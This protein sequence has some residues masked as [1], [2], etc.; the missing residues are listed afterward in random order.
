MDAGPHGIIGRRRTMSGMKGFAQNGHGNAGVAKVKDAYWRRRSKKKYHESFALDKGYCSLPSAQ[1]T[2]QKFRQTWRGSLESRRRFCS[3]RRRRNA[4]LNGRRRCYDGWCDGGHAVGRRRWA[5]HEVAVHAYRNEQCTFPTCECEWS[6]WTSW[7]TGCGVA[8]SKRSK[9]KKIAKVPRSAGNSHAFACPANLAPSP[10]NKNADILSASTTVVMTRNDFSTCGRCV[11]HDI[12]AAKT[13]LRDNADELVCYTNDCTGP[14][15]V[16]YTHVAASHQALCCED[17]PRCSTFSCGYKTHHKNG[18]DWNWNLRCLKDGCKDSGEQSHCCEQN[19]GRCNEVVCYNIWDGWLQK[20]SASSIVCVGQPCGKSASSLAER[21]NCCVEGCANPAAAD[22]RGFQAPQGWLIIREDAAVAYPPYPDPSRRRRSNWATVSTTRLQC[23]DSTHV[24]T[25]SFRSVRCIASKEPLQ[26]DGGSCRE[27]CVPKTGFDVSY[28]A[29][30]ICGKDFVKDI[31]DHEKTCA[32]HECGSFDWNTCCTQRCLNDPADHYGFDAKG[33]WARLRERPTSSAG[34]GSGAYPGENWKT[35]LAHLSCAGSTH[36]PKATPKYKCAQPGGTLQLDLQD[37]REKC[38]VHQNNLALCTS[39]NAHMTSAHFAVKT[40]ANDYCSD[41]RCD[42]ASDA[43]TCCRKKCTHPDVQCPSGFRKNTSNFCATAPNSCKTL[44]DNDNDPNFRSCCIRVCTSTFCRVSFAGSFLKSGPPECSDYNCGGKE[45]E[46]CCVQPCSKPNVG[47]NQ[48]GDGFELKSSGNNDWR[49]LL[50]NQQNCDKTSC[51]IAVPGQS[52]TSWTTGKLKC[53]STHAGTPRYRCPSAKSV[54]NPLSVLALDAGSCREKCRSDDKC[55]SHYQVRPASDNALCATNRCGTSDRPACCRMMCSEGNVVDF[56][57]SS[58]DYLERK[59]TLSGEVCAKY[60][61]DTQSDKE[62]CCRQQCRAFDSHLSGVNCGSGYSRIDNSQTVQCAA[63]ACTV[64]ADK[65]TCCRETCGRRGDTFCNAFKSGAAQYFKRIGNAIAATKCSSVACAGNADRNT[66]CEIGCTQAKTVVPH[67]YLI[68]DWSH[69]L[70]NAYPRDSS[71]DEVPLSG[72][73]CDTSKLMCDPVSHRVSPLDGDTNQCPTWQCAGSNKGLTFYGC[74]ELCHESDTMKCAHTHKRTPRPPAET[75]LCVSNRCKNTHEADHDDVDTCCYPKCSDRF[76]GAPNNRECPPPEKGFIA[77]G[78]RD[79]NDCEDLACDSVQETVSCCTRRRV[80]PHI[81]GVTPDELGIFVSGGSLSL[82]FGGD[83]TDSAVVADTSELDCKDERVWRD[84]TYQMSGIFSTEQRLRLC[85]TNDKCDL[86]DFNTHPDVVDCCL[87][88]VKEPGWFCDSFHT[89]RFY[90]TEEEAKGACDMGFWDEENGEVATTLCYGYQ[91]DENFFNFDVK[92]TY[93]GTKGLVTDTSKYGLYSLLL[94]PIEKAGDEETVTSAGTEYLN[95]RM[96]AGNED[97]AMRESYRRHSSIGMKPNCVRVQDGL[98]D[99]RYN[100]T[101]IDA[102]KAT[103]WLK[104]S[105]LPESKDLKPRLDDVNPDMLNEARLVALFPL[106]VAQKEIPGLSA[107]TIRVAMNTEDLEELEEEQKAAAA[108]HAAMSSFASSATSFRQTADEKNTGEQL[109][110]HDSA[111][112]GSQMP[113]V[114]DEKRHRARPRR[115]TSTSFSA[116]R[117]EEEEDEDTTFAEKLQKAVEI[118]LNVY[119]EVGNFTTPVDTSHEATDADLGEVNATEDDS[120]GARLLSLIRKEETTMKDAGGEVT[121]KAAAALHLQT[122]DAAEGAAALS[123]SRAQDGASLLQERQLHEEHG[124]DA[125]RTKKSS[126]QI[127]VLAGKIEPADEGPNPFNFSLYFV[128]T[129]P[130]EGSETLKKFHNST[131]LDEAVRKTLQKHILKEQKNLTNNTTTM[132][133]QGIQIQLVKE[134]TFRGIAGGEDGH[135]AAASASFSLADVGDEANLENLE[136]L[137]SVMDRELD[138]ELDQEMDA[139]VEASK[140]SS[141]LSSPYLQVF[142]ARRLEKKLVKRLEI[143]Q[144]EIRQ[145]RHA[146]RRTMLV[147]S[148]RKKKMAKYKQ[149]RQQSG[150]PP[151]E[152]E[153]GG[154]KKGHQNRDSKRRSRER[155]P[156]SSNNSGSSALMRQQEN[157]HGD[158]QSSPESAF[159]FQALFEKRSRKKEGQS[160]GLEPPYFLWCDLK[161]S[162][163]D[164]IDAWWNPIL[165]FEFPNGKGFIVLIVSFG[166]LFLVT[167]RH[168]LLC[169]RRPRPKDPALQML[170]D[171]EFDVDPILL[172]ASAKHG[173]KKMKPPKAASK[174]GGIKLGLA[175]GEFYQGQRGLSSGSP[176]SGKPSTSFAGG[177]AASSGFAKSGAFGAGSG[178]FGA[179]SGAFGGGSAAA[180]SAAFGKPAATGS[181]AF[182]AP[183]SGGASSAFGASAAFGKK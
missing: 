167:C 107:V 78:N 15:P 181:A 145:K 83:A 63:L 79:N 146:W 153:A 72:G 151:R 161:P 17:N 12:C 129:Q 155:G 95:Y 39:N 140:N 91:Y 132:D 37:C 4:P 28:G 137:G 11:D 111:Q 175:G 112:R 152:S 6:S 44:A 163:L 126:D 53:S 172:A 124:H 42:R 58:G 128:G 75:N 84:G 30:K 173:R 22:T 76:F 171:G 68:A 118:S 35:N 81:V 49:D 24:Q 178:A 169:S 141:D 103:V 87:S 162:A 109:D 93:Q 38:S 23:V 97:S 71:P 122:E 119:L 20:S 73:V 88:Y 110:G 85:A 101:L 57:A 69:L 156:V 9:Y 130:T 143:R 160:A 99:T 144:A 47:N 98:A 25:G 46:T 56:C 136:A 21:A 105:R 3:M 65:G 125:R 116:S 43:N 45:E 51:G 13:H 61:C 16:G 36:Y 29:G 77:N 170:E 149:K 102:T 55:P 14:V 100:A 179:G 50:K 106:A 89:P 31:D 40:G 115:S 60:E 18:A 2:H 66:C 19:H 33:H 70:R 180:G 62:L 135:A 113:G 54:P 1:R 174:I 148:M 41:H 120:G 94:P 133:L 114:E 108:G 158:E 183:K 32:T 134:V 117:T 147:E 7:T 159:S 90:A 121:K 182:G 59:K 82:Y 166:L 177:A 92:D 67:G 74:R 96:K 164:E 104:S 52:G 8:V 86:G 80:C 139:F 34:P 138:K 64:D 5:G 127:S 157:E 165:L 123:S 131:K 154:E 10:D 168:Y 27:R 48:V 142:H 150:R 26:I 176:I